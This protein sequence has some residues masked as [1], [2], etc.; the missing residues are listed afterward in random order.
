M[1]AKGV[2]MYTC[3]TYLR[4]DGVGVPKSQMG[5]NA[6]A[7]APGYFGREKL[8]TEGKGKGVL[9]QQNFA[10]FIM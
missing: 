3:I 7:T 1:T 9:N 10:Y 2:Y 4:S 6:Y 8:L 5:Q